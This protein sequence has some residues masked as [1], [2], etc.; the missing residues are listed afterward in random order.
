MPRIGAL[1]ALLA[2]FT[3]GCA[4]APSALA[5]EQTPGFMP[6]D[7]LIELVNWSVLIVAE[8]SGRTSN[9]EPFFYVAYVTHEPILFH[10]PPDPKSPGFHDRLWAEMQSLGKQRRATLDASRFT[11]LIIEAREP[12]GAPESRARRSVFLAR[13]GNWI[14][15]FSIHLPVNQ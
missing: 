15:D 11:Y 1:I 3:T 5:Y 8:G 7:E 12:P 9:D 10:D 14:A 13:N 6:H 2:H 4:S